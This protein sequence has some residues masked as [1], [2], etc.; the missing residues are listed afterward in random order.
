MISKLSRR[1]HLPSKDEHPD[2][3]VLEPEVEVDRLP[4]LDL[5]IQ[6]GGYKL[7]FVSEYSDL[8]HTV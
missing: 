4:R 3:D 6:N 1:R 7:R 5:K 8:K 2:D